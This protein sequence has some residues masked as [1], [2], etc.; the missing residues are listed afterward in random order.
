[1]ELIMSGQEETETQY[2]QMRDGIPS[3]KLSNRQIKFKLSQFG[4]SSKYSALQR[5]MSSGLLNGRKNVFEKLHRGPE[6][7]QLERYAFSPNAKQL[8]YSNRGALGTNHISG[9]SSS[10]AATTNPNAS[11]FTNAVDIINRR[12][13]KD[14]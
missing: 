14:D 11:T 7:L 3:S 13:S 12:K 4:D 5:N 8:D 2:S 6:K 9:Q 10:K 1:M